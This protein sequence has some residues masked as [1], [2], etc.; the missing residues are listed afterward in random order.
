MRTAVPATVII[1]VVCPCFGL[2]S[3]NVPLDHWSYDAVDKLVGQGL[4]RSSMLTTKPVSRLEMA[5]LIAE[6]V[7]ESQQSAFLVTK[8]AH[9]PFWLSPLKHHPACLVYLLP[10]PRNSLQKFLTISNKLLPI[11]LSK[12][13]A[14]SLLQPIAL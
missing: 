13:S 9:L 11:V 2:V 14:Q 7:E 12:C 1:A 10:P 3:T 8:N 5:R 6:A 4:I